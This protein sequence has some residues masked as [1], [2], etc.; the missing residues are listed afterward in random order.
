MTHYCPVCKST[1]NIW[2]YIVRESGGN[3]YYC[4]LCGYILDTPTKPRDKN[5][6]ATLGLFAGF[7]AILMTI[8]TLPFTIYEYYRKKRFM[9]RGDKREFWENLIWWIRYKT[10]L[11]VL[12]VR[13]GR[14]LFK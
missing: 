2:H 6:P 5:V 10:R 4:G 3:K 7:L 13:K 11:I 12:I 1:H 8:I 9:K 14:E